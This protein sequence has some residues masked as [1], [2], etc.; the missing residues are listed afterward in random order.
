MVPPVAGMALPVAGMVPH[1]AGMIVC[2]LH[3]GTKRIV[4]WSV[5][6]FFAGVNETKYVDATYLP[7]LSQV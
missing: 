7:L 4:F 2:T 5:V 6:F 3:I 1:V